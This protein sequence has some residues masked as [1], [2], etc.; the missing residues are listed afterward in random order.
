MVGWYPFPKRPLDHPE[1]AAEKSAYRKFKG[2]FIVGFLMSAFGNVHCNML[3][4]DQGPVRA[5]ND[6]IDKRCCFAAKLR[7]EPIPTNAA[8]RT[9]VGFAGFDANHLTLLAI[10]LNFEPI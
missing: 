1:P 6:L 7:F 10:V 9:N 5:V 3:T 8:G 4:V 2:G